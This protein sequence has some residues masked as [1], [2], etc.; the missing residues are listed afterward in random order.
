MERKNYPALSGIRFLF[1]MII[2]FYHCWPMVGALQPGKVALFFRANGGN[3][4]NYMFFMISG[5]LMSVHY[6]K[7]LMNDQDR[8]PLHVFLLKR[9]LKL[10]P[11]YFITM[12]AS[13]LFN[14][15]YS[16]LAFVNFKEVIFNA[17]LLSTGYVEE[18]N[19]YNSPQWFACVLMLCYLVFYILCYLARKH[20]YAFT[21]GA[22][23]LALWGYILL[24]RSWSAPFCYP[25]NGEG[26]FNFFL[27]CLL[28]EFL[29]AKSVTSHVKK[30]V[31]ITGGVLSVLFF[32]IA[33][34]KGFDRL[35][36]DSRY[37]FSL[38]ICPAILM[39]AVTFRWMDHVF[40]NRVMS[41]LGKL[42]TAIFFWHIP[43]YQYLYFNRY[44]KGYFFNDSPH[45]VRLAVYL[46]FLFAIC[47]VSYILVEKM[48]GN[49][50]NKKL[51]AVLAKQ[52][53]V[54]DTAA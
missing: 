12:C 11:L 7:K 34:S 40:G 46:A 29:Q 35:S 54:Q 33:W 39:L 51:N 45:F 15:N 8:L 41:L 43:L 42:S 31:A 38:L 30:G 3:W 21:Y 20:K 52:K 28:A 53:Q 6:K 25:K 36:G 2:V 27:G 49:Y 14:L 23:L 17:L 9:L 19:Q 24:T 26:F 37:T 10:Y 44:Q 22:L 13:I 32:L 47:A 18:L 5:F 16:G 1:I 50:L 4:G 48:L